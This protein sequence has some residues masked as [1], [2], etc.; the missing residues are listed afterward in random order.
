M[1]DWNTPVLAGAKA[2]YYC[3]DTYGL[4]HLRRTLTLANYMRSTVPD[5]SQLI[6][7]GSPMADRFQFPQGTDYVKLPS[8]TKNAI[9][10]Y[11]PRSLA[12]GFDVVRNMRRDILFSAARHFQPDFFIVDHA[13]AGMRGE[14]VQT[15]RHLKHAFPQTKLVVGLRDVMDEAAAV[16]RSW[17]REGIYE[18]LD[19]VYDLIMVYG[20]RGLFDVV[21]EYGLSSRAA[22]KTRFVGYLGR[23][24]GRQSREQ[25]RAGLGMQTDRLVVVTGGGGGDASALYDA[26]LRDL[27]LANGADFDCLI[28]NGPFLDES[29]HSAIRERFINQD[30]VHFLDF[31]SDLP[32]YLNAADA[33]V[34]MGG[35]NSVCEIL[36]LGKPAIIVPRTEPRKEQLIRARMLAGRG[37]LQMIHPN[38][39][40]P[41]RLIAATNDLLATSA[42]ERPR[43]VMDGLGNVLTALGSLT[44]FPVQGWDPAAA[45]NV[46]V[47]SFASA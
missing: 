2:M 24:P 47:S 13:P 22:A 5:I 32:S 10:E 42:V 46:P 12:S 7:T 9:G 33:V 26:M 38:D 8:V 35:Y 29:A 43:L 14:A 45:A 6:V 17:A 44:R 27:Q 19:D 1:F 34:S 28:V 18:L 21:G 4:G 15:L 39:L 30:R 31:T 36:A 3:H 41:G 40:T 23:E 37:L 11:E 16:R 25:I 20:Q